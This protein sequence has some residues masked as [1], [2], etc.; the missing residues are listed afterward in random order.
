[1]SKEVLLAGESRTLMI[2]EA[3]KKLQ[4]IE[5]RMEKNM[6]DITR[7]ASKIST[8]KPL[9][10]TEDIQRKKIKSLVQANTDL[11]TTYLKIKMDI[12]YSNL[13]T[14]VE[15]MGETYT[16]SELLVLK[17][18]LAKMMER[19]YTALNS[20]SAEH[21]MHMMRSSH[22]SQPAHIDRLYTED[23]RDKGLRRWQDLYQN[24]NSRLEVVNATTPLK[25]R[26][27]S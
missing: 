21:R 10:E 18:K 27:T 4:H 8:E 7:Y 6:K 25:E 1:M 13:V 14:T 9:F 19:T 12:E 3:M 11:A 15:L 23:E 26:P 2:S 16:L 24:I 20:S 17:R 5:E 22:D